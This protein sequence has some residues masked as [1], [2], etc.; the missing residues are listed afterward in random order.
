MKNTK[1]TKKIPEPPEFQPKW[2]WA[3]VAFMLYHMPNGK[4]RLIQEELEKFPLNNMPEV[5]YDH[6]RKAWIMQLK[7]GAMPTIVT[8]PKKMLKR[9][10][11]LILS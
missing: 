3:F 6:D 7:K 4:V 9:N 2:Y 10:R 8:V 1:N 11:K 5:L